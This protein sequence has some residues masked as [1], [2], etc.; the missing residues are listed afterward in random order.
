MKRGG[1]ERIEEIAMKRFAMF[2]SFMALLFYVLFVCVV[3]CVLWMLLCGFRFDRQI[4]IP[5]PEIKERVE[6][7]KLHLSKLTL[8]SRKEMEEEEQEQNKK[9][10]FEGGLCILHHSSL[11]PPP[12]TS[13]KMEWGLLA[14]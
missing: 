13:N 4:H 2:Y 10:F 8:M 12:A 9:V 6:I 1:E 3:C 5:K 7:F 14:P 11:C